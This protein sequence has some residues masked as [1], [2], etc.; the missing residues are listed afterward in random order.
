MQ[1]KSKNSLG[2]VLKTA[3]NQ[4]LD[5]LLGDFSVLAPRIKHLSF[6]STV[7][8]ER[9]CVRASYISFRDDQ[10]TF[11]EFIEVISDHII[12]FCL[13]RSEIRDAKAAIV[14][15][16]HATAGRIM[17][18][19][20]E[21]ARAL[22]IKAKEG[23]HRS[24][25]AGE[26]VLYILNEWILHA[27]QIVSKMYL[28]TNNQ[29]P[30]HGTD[31]IH[32]RYDGATK[33]LLLY[34]GESKAHSKL[35]S[36]LSDA[37]ASISEFVEKSHERKEIELVAA[38]ADLDG[39]DS[40]GKEA[41]LRYLDPYSSESN[42]RI[43]IHSCLLVF[44]FPIPPSTEPGAA[45]KEFCAEVNGAVKKFIK[46]IKNTVENRGLGAQ[47]FE[48]SS[49]LCLLCRDFA[50]NFKPKSGGRNDRRACRPRLVTRKTAP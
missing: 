31:G 50:T 49:C 18:R 19:L 16:D 13:P 20:N 2:E 6:D 22:F 48:F 45:E 23:S 43:A 36:A 42:E 39:V 38:H 12:P 5:R 9:I 11:D 14:S 21:K 47:R 35:A 30:V 41:I 10:P 17:T 7:C 34:W 32:A 15:G 28:K 26:I 3:I 24:G 27:P 29:M 4:Q 37:L 1:S 44:E 33:W 25:E 46:D 8:G 40:E